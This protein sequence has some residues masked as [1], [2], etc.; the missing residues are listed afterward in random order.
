MFPYKLRFRT[1]IHIQSDCDMHKYENAI[2]DWVALAGY[3]VYVVPSSHESECE[4]R[5][6][7]A[8]LK[9]NVSTDRRLVIVDMRMMRDLRYFNIMLWE[10][11]RND[12]IAQC[13]ACGETPYNF[14]TI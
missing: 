8:H 6:A 14:K 4:E 12:L 9:R 2:I 10:N 5:Q 11:Y 1:K 7:F 3:Q 13:P